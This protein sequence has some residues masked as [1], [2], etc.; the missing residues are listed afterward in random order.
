MK[1]VNPL[2]FVTVINLNLRLLFFGEVDFFPPGESFLSPLNEIIFLGAFSLL[3]LNE[4]S[5]LICSKLF[6]RVVLN[7]N[8]CATH[9]L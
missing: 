9:F 3:Q 2:T 6:S 1:D 8:E 7:T 4:F 5:R